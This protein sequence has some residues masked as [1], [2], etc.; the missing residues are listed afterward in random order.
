MKFITHKMCPFAQK[1]WIGLEL[2]N[3]PYEL[4]EIA[5]YGANGKPAWFRSLNPKGTVPTLVNDDDTVWT[6]SDD[7]LDYLEE[8]TEGSFSEWR[9]DL[10]NHRLLPAA[11][12]VVLSGENYNEELQSILQE[13]NDHEVIRNMDDLNIAHCHA[14][15]FLWRLDQDCFIDASRF[16]NI[17]TWLRSCERH[18]AVAKTIQQNWWWWW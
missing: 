10:I 8:R 14:F 6:D 17:E 2:C 5:L 4:Q 16:A 12:L 13:I 11:K 15:P 3:V 18:P 9:Y 7:I 1:A